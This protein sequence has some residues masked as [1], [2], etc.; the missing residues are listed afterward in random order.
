[1]DSD[2]WARVLALLETM[3]AQEVAQFIVDGVNSTSP[4]N[5]QEMEQWLRMADCLSELAERGHLN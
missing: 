5:R 3:P 1:M 4:D 2:A